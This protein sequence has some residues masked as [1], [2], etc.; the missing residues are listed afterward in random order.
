MRQGEWLGIADGQVAVAAP[1]QPEALRALLDVLVTADAELV[2]LLTG[3]GADA[4]ATKR[5]E[6]WLEA[7]RA[8]VELEVAEGG[9]PL[10]PFLISVE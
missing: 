6:E 9:Q 7:E 8:G 5:V 10:Y 1:D 3:D 2:T 4:G